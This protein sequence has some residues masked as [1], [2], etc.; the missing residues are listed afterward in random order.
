MSCHRH[1][2]RMLG[3]VPGDS[4]PSITVICDDC[5]QLGSVDEPTALELSR[6]MVETDEYRPEFAGAEWRIRQ[7]STP[8]KQEAKT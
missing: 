1:D 8:Q 5:G 2:W 3:V 7:I 6:A 4:S